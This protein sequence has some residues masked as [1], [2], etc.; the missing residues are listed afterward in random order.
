MTNILAHGALGNFDEL[1]F[2]GVIVIFIIMMALSWLRSL[3]EDPSLLD[4]PEKQ[5]REENP[6]TDAEH[7][8]LD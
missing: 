3:N 5:K 4:E 1:I 8:R 2:I 6:S 7:F